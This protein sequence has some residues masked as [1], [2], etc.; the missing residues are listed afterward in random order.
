M[1]TFFNKHVRNTYHNAVTFSLYLLINV[2]MYL[3]NVAL[4]QATTFSKFGYLAS[5]TGH[6]AV[7]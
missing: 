2:V 7:N 1:G 4:L 3:D 5:S 6:N